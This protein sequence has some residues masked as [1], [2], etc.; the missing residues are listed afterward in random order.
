L[1]SDGPHATLTVAKLGLPDEIVEMQLARDMHCRA[2]RRTQ[3]LEKR[4]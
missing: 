1:A 2:Y 3:W 4:R